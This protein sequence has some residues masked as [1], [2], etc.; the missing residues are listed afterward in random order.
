MISHHSY[1][2]IALLETK[3][4]EVHLKNY[5]SSSL[6]SSSSAVHE[7]DLIVREIIGAEIFDEHNCDTRRPTINDQKQSNNNFKKQADGRQPNNKKTRKH[8]PA[9]GES[10]NL[11]CLP[12]ALDQILSHKSSPT[13]SSNKIP[14]WEKIMWNSASVL[15]N[16][17]PSPSFVAN[18]QDR[19]RHQSRCDST[20]NKNN[21]GSKEG[22]GLIFQGSVAIATPGDLADGGTGSGTAQHLA[23]LLDSP[24][25]LCVL[26]VL[27]IRVDSRYTTFRRLAIHEAAAS[28]SPQCLQLLMEL[29][30][31]F[32]PSFNTT[33][34]VLSGG[35]EISSATMT[36]S[37]QKRSST[38]GKKK[39][40]KKLN[41]MFTG[42][43]HKG[44]SLEG[45]GDS[46]LKNSLADDCKTSNNKA[47][48]FPQVALTLKVLWD[49]VQ[50]LGSGDIENEMEAALYVLDRVKVSDRAMLILASPQ[51][52]HHIPE[53]TPQSKDKAAAVSP[54]SG[55]DLMQSDHHDLRSL[56]VKSNVDGNGNTP[57]HWAAFKGSVRAMKVL[58]SFDVDVNA[59]AQ[60][61]WSPLHDAAYSDSAG[62]T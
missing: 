23:C 45:Y 11:K 49:A 43:W 14:D 1:S 13:S 36:P 47:S 2:Y 61:G 22:D 9:R 7:L 33:T 37:Q 40:K 27:G 26:I 29:G 62:K 32:S 17:A 53:N 54:F 8:S 59:R 30:A 4:D 3:S 42:K 16:T 25:A 38:N 44:K 31:R 46:T 41:N 12:S 5:K 51:C 35:T 18:R 19:N 20:K 58:L 34:A 52:S 55:L 28:D 21:N 48:S 50:K 39:K 56:I 6:S 60:S 10:T 15:S 57:L 24:F